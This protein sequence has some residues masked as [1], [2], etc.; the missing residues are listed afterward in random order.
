MYCNILLNKL[1]KHINLHSQNVTFDTL[2][3][4]P[5]HE[6]KMASKSRKSSTVTG[7]KRSLPDLNV[8]PKKKESIINEKD[9]VASTVNEG[10]FSSKFRRFC[11]ECNENVVPNVRTIYREDVPNKRLSVNNK[12]TCN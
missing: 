3:T 5:I 6:C 4:Y 1:Q 11:L 9:I 2:E 7:S 10:E 12:F 8:L